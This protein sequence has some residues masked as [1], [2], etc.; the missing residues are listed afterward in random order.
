MVKRVSTTTALDRLRKAYRRHA[1]AWA[2]QHLDSPEVRDEP[3]ASFPLHPPTQQTVL[4]DQQASIDWVT[5]WRTHTKLTDYVRWE[6]R[7]WSLVGNQRVPV[8]LMVHDPADVAALT[9]QISHWNSLVTRFNVLRQ[10]LDSTSDKVQ[11]TLGRNTEAIAA[12][13]DVDFHRLVAVLSWLAQH[14]ES[15]LYIRQLPIRG[16][17]TKWVTAHRRLVQQ[18]HTANTG[19]TDLGIRPLPE[20]WRIR[21]LDETMWFDGL[22]DL[23][24]PVEQLAQLQ[25]V[26]ARVLIVENL[27]SL[28]TMPPMKNTV[29]I[30]GKG[31]A[32]SGLA[33]I[34][35]IHVAQVFYWGDLDTHGFGILHSLRASGI[36]TTSLLMDLATLQQFEDLWVAEAKPF[37]GTLPL[38]TT[39][40]SQTLQYLQDHPGTRL[41]QERIDWSYVVD[42]LSDR[43][44]LTDQLD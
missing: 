21:L 9:G 13:Q 17:D 5:S 12:L 30:F 40:E 3:A 14:P 19:R 43:G 7:Q 41:E 26:P 2:L 38:L 44:L 39:A 34:P 16:V 31:T 24:A 10:E 4:Q 36:E 35:W 32:V 8:R 15:Q 6:N 11:A 1:G 22:S 33:R 23:T 27:I 42:T 28:L 29:A 20:L 18:L 25:L 37:R